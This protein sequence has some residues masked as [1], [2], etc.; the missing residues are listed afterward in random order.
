M[1]YPP[2]QTQ[3]YVIPKTRKCKNR[4][5]QTWSSFWRENEAAVRAR[6]RESARYSTLRSPRS[7]K[8]RRAY[9]TPSVHHA[10]VLTRV[11]RCVYARRS[12][13]GDRCVLCAIWC[14]PKT[15]YTTSRVIYI[16]IQHQARAAQSRQFATRG[17]FDDDAPTA[18]SPFLCCV[19]ARGLLHNKLIGGAARTL[20]PCSLHCLAPFLALANDEPR[21]SAIFRD[22][23][24]ALACALHSRPESNVTFALRRGCGLRSALFSPRGIYSCIYVYARI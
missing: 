6:T 17:F 21:A 4:F 9:T 18:L 7:I 24:S 13:E 12:A 1:T 5:G 11:V 10:L 23:H 22:W 3:A 19:H 16:R 20:A 8:A 15:R 14:P 2:I